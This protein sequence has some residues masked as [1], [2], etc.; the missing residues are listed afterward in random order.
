MT[1][2]QFKIHQFVLG[3]LIKEVALVVYSALEEDKQYVKY[4]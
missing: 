3:L 1:S 2:L 4:V